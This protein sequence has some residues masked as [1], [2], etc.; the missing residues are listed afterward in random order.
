VSFWNGSFADLLHIAGVFHADTALA[1]VFMP[2]ALVR[3]KWRKKMAPV[4]HGFPVF[5]ALVDVA[6][7]LLSAI[8]AT[9]SH[10]LVSREFGGSVGF[11]LWMLFLVSTCFVALSAA[12]NDYAIRHYLQTNRQFRRTF[13]PWYL[14]FATAM[15]IA[16]SLVASGPHAPLPI[17]IFFAVGF[18]SVSTGRI[19][20]AQSV[21][22]RAAQ[23]RVAAKR[24]FLIGFESELD[25]FTDR[26]EVHRFGM[27][28]VAAS[29]LRSREN[30]AEDLA[31]ARAYARILEPDDVLV[32][33]PWSDKVTIDTVITAFLGVPVAIHLGPEKIIDR[34]AAARI[35]TIGPFASINLVES[36]LPPEAIFV[37][38]L[39]DIVCASFGLVI[40]SPLLLLVALAIK[41]DSRGPIIFRQKRYG[42]NQQPFRIFKFRSLTTCEDSAALTPVARDDMRLTRV[43]SFMRRHNIDELPQLLNVILGDMSLVGPRPM[44][45]I[46][47]QMFEPLI[48]L[49]SRR[50]NVKP[51]ITG[52]AQ[53]NGHRGELTQ[54]G[55]RSRIEYDLYYIDHWSLWFD[56]KILW[57][58]LTTKQ[59]YINAF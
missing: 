4:S 58:T 51:G 30:L 59:G 9:L 38:R 46:H 10:R 52:W 39:I 42:F 13:A 5:A 11:H 37:K 41:L 1:H 36:P 54:E 50:H 22:A 24:L 2:A 16:L 45:I 44:A 12:R 14:A 17:L 43:G 19:I 55:I 18:A 40:L 29:V 6:A 25:S 15:V 23:G 21:S 48:A 34:F 28:I 3:A 7:I 32:L 31:L 35:E 56:I 27:H 49:Y 53:I 33:V 26:F 57:C 47:D 8:A 20:L